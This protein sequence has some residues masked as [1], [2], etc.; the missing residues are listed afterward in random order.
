MD[1]TTAKILLVDD[2]VNTLKVLSAILRK[3]GYEVATAT[4]AEEALEKLPALDADAVVVDYKL[5]GMNGLE[6][7]QAVKRSG[8]PVPV[9]MLTAFGTIEK[10]VEAMKQGAFMY[11][12]KPVNPDQ[13]LTVTREAVEKNHLFRENL[14]LKTQLKERYGSGNL[15]GKGPA[16]QEIFGLID[17]VS[18][19]AS[20]VLVM[21]ESGTGKELV[22]RAI[23]CESPRNGGPF[24][25]LDCAALPEETLESEIFGHEKGSFT[26]AHERKVGQIELGNGGTL[27]LDEVGELSLN[28]QKKF[29]RFLQEREFLRVGGKQR[30]KVDVRIIAATNRELRREVESGR[31]R[32]DLFYRLNVVVVRVPALRERREDIPMLLNHFLRRFNEENHKLIT[33]VD[34]AVLDAFV[35]HDWPGNVRELENAVERAVVLCTTDTVTMQHLPRSLRERQAAAAP[36][37]RGNG[38]GLFENEKRLLLEALEKAGWNQTKTAEVLGISRKQLRTRM[39]NHDLLPAPD[40]SS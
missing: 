34:G 38:F 29:L 12:A 26:G 39:K 8:R 16:I 6:F 11:V 27:F 15:I 22:A 25:T 18:K 31:F 30:I 40:R 3:A 14:S 32:E 28:V 35:N 37:S 2:E 9:I 13:L 23:H 19:S 36:P 4:T 10:A 21:G 20:S 33:G 1:R 17:T 5:P 24:V 7:I